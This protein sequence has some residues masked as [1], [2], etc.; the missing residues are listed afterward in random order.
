MNYNINICVSDGL[1]Q[2]LCK[3]HLTP[4]GAENHCVLC[5]LFM[6]RLEDFS[7]THYNR[8]K[9]NGTDDCNTVQKWNEGR[10]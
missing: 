3:D 5:T 9:S 4:K 10:S 8:L 2:P 6:Y 7:I 1:R